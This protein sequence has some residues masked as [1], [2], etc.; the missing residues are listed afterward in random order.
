MTVAGTLHTNGNSTTNATTYDLSTF[1]TTAGDLLLLFVLHEV[2]AATAFLMSRPIQLV[3][4]D[5]WNSWPVGFVCLDAPGS[6]GAVKTIL[7]CWAVAPKTN[8]GTAQIRLSFA[9]TQDG[10]IWAAIKVT[11]QGLGATPDFTAGNGRAPYHGLK[12]IRQIG[13]TSGQDIIDTGLYTEEARLFASR[14]PTTSLLIAAFGCKENLN[15]APPTGWTELS[16]QKMATPALGMQVNKIDSGYSYY[17]TETIVTT[18][19]AW[20][21]LILELPLLGSSGFTTLP[22][23]AIYA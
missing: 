19:S 21:A 11:G 4:S 15:G 6:S 8:A 14:T 10:I 23:R 9:D 18:G 17:A 13:I 12:C 5:P 16:D 7:E 20:G 1:A 2:V 22:E 3:G